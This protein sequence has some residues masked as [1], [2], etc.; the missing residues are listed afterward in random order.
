MHIEKVL[1]REYEAHPIKLDSPSASDLPNES[2]NGGVVFQW[3]CGL[4][5][6]KGHQAVLIVAGHFPAFVWSMFP[7]VRPN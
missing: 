3:R 1:G 5:Y 4:Q 7:S 2:S 6:L